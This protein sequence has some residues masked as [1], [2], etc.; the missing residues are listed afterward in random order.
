[1]GQIYDFGEG[2]ACP[3]YALSSK[4]LESIRIGRDRFLIADTDGGVEHLGRGV[5][6]GCDVILTIVEP[7][8]VFTR[9]QPKM[10]SED[11]ADMMRAVPGA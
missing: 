11:F 4:F 10:G 8:K 7:S 2:C 6:H 9:S 1:M 5:E 3:I